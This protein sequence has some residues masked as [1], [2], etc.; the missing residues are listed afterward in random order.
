VTPG[1]RAGGPERPAERTERIE[2]IE[3][4]LA[5]DADGTV[6]VRSGKVDYG[7]GLRTAF[8]R[9][10][11][12]ELSVPMEQ[13]RLE[14]GE[15]DRTP[16]DMGTFGS[17]SIATDGASLRAAAAF[18]RTL[19]VRRASA[20]LGVPADALAVRDG[21]VHASDGRRVSYQDLTGGEPLT[22]AVPDYDPDESTIVPAADA[23]FRLEAH[24][25]VTGRARFAADV[26]LPGMLRGHVLPPPAFGMHLASVDD[27]AARGLPGVRAIV[28]EGEFVG[29]VADRDEQAL[30][31]V[32]ALEATWSDPEI[33]AVQPTQLVMRR[34]E[35]LTGPLPGG[36]LTLDARFFMP[37]ISHAPIGPSAAVADVRQDAVDLYVSTQ[38]PFALRDEIA[39][40]LDRPADEIRVHPQS[41]SGAFGRTNRHD[42]VYDAA[43]LSRAVERPVLV[44]WTRA[45]EFQLSPQRPAL[46][47]EVHATIDSAGDILSWRYHANTNPHAYGDAAQPT[48]LLE[49]TAGRNALPPY[50]LGRAD[51][52]LQILPAA[53]RTGPFRSL[54][55]ALHVFAIESFMDELA[56]AASQDPIAFRLR[57]IDDARLRR[58]LEAVRERSAWSYR[59]REDG[60]GFGVAC[61]IYH[62]TPIAQVAE[63]VVSASGRTHVERVWCVA[64]PGRLVHP[65]GARQQIEGGIQQAASWALL[66]ELRHQDNAV[67]TTSWLEYPMATFLDAPRHV[68]VAFTSDPETPSTGVGEPGSVPTAAA[69][70]NAIFD[71]CGARLRRLPLSPAAIAGTRR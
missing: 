66:E 55:A 46:D 18:A 12:E 71:A 4:R 23:P 67:M 13:I 64:D 62:G 61:A 9:I 3:Q 5:I 58:V 48:R 28:H 33:D 31:A 10:V 22:G 65:D 21:Q 53:V 32:R 25:I 24:D 44:Q 60:R 16:W 42:V 45:E 68:D 11:A 56:A 52:S 37:H 35:R 49:V 2:Q 29:V 26:R 38:R 19:L 34:D 17:M 59:A 70:A 7:Q 41:M 40:L 47:A 50:R 69:I 1:R 15:T 27:R 51:V 20:R 57:L 36:A 14:L 6:I 43:R 8:A 30:A 39:E 63:V 54:A